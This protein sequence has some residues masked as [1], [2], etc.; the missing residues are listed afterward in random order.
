MPRFVRAFIMLAVL[1]LGLARAGAEPATGLGSSGLR[2][3]TSLLE[4]NCINLVPFS[5]S[6]FLTHSKYG[7]VSLST[8][9]SNLEGRWWWD[10]DHFFTNQASHPYHGSLYF[11]S[12]R[13]LG[14]DYY[15][16]T[17]VTMTGSFIWEEFMENQPP[18][19]NDL[20]DTT[21]GGSMLG[22]MFYRLHA[23]SPSPF[24]ALLL[25]PMAWLNEKVFGAKPAPMRGGIERGESS[26]SVG[27]LCSSK[28]LDEARGPSARGTE[29]GGELGLHLVYGKAYG[30]Q[31][32]V[33]FESFE[34]RVELSFTPSY[35]LFSFLSEGFLAS[36]APIDDSRDRTSLG[37]TMSYDF[38]FGSDINFVANSL[39]LSFKNEHRTEGDWRLRTQLSLGAV[40]L[41]G[42]DYIY[43]R[44][45][46]VPPLEPDELDRRNY[47]FGA[48][49]TAKLSFEVS[50]LGLG[51]L[52]LW[53]AGYNLST[54]PG[55]VPRYGSGGD[56]LIGLGSL[57]YS[58]PV[59]QDL[60]IELGEDVYGKLGLYASADRVSDWLGRTSLRAKW[61]L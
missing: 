15:R 29:G 58:L 3:S 59:W 43:L 50:K 54:I 45:G 6:L 57:S 21:F 14:Y 38:V 51:E 48:G 5:V 12:G 8:M 9:E 35:Y 60:S 31:T 61:S 46:D 30:L 18:S 10:Q 56:S 37:P 20:V 7:E 53:L 4:V 33:P 49:E 13:S 34:Q 32:S 36:W 19:I 22:E 24:L 25:S 55:S 17:L 52:K 39:A 11:G 1:S 41:G 2:A 23:E 40:L 47:D 27:T 44:Y 26:V 28:G 42:T 16:S